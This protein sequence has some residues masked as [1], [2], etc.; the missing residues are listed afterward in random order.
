[1]I[2]EE[3][4]RNQTRVLAMYQQILEQKGRIP[5]KLPVCIVVD[6]TWSLQYTANERPCTRT[7]GQE[8]VKKG[9]IVAFATPDIL[10]LR[11]N[12]MEEFLWYCSVQDVPV[13]SSL[14]L[15]DGKSGIKVDL[16]HLDAKDSALM[17]HVRVYLQ[18]EYAAAEYENTKATD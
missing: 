6:N 17:N 2:D 11:W 18:A 14:P 13:F 15:A 16:F 7:L 4:V 9:R 3:T 10:T 8:L 12:E 1:M 5:K